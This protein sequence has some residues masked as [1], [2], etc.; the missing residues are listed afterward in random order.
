[1]NVAKNKRKRGR[2]SK[3]AKITENATPQFGKV[4]I[5]LGY[6]S[7]QELAPET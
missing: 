4:C 2:P 7:P 6:E 5:D 1:M 3:K